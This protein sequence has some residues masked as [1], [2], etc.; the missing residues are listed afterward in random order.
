M[1]VGP[2]TNE[3]PALVMGFGLT[4]ENG[5][6]QPCHMLEAEITKYSP[7]Q[8]KA[9]MLPDDDTSEDSVFCAGADNKDTCQV[10]L[11]QGNSVLYLTVINIYGVEFGC[12]I[13]YV[14]C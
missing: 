11:H 13:N 12:E 10:I 4:R 7:E 1:F 14:N 9:S 6:E 8:C 2:S 5:N 3:E